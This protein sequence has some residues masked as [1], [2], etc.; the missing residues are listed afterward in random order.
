MLVY[1]YKSH[2]ETQIYKHNT[3]HNLNHCLIR[4]LFRSYGTKQIR[5]TTDSL[6][7]RTEFLKNKCGLSGKALITVS[8]CLT[9]DSSNTRPDSVLDL[10]R[11]FGF[12]QT[13]IARIVSI[14]PRCLEE[15][16]PENA[17]KPKLD[18]LLSKDLT[19][20]E[21]VAIV[22]QNPHILTSSL[23]NHIIP[24]L[25]LL[26]S[27]TGCYPNVAAVLK[28]NPYVLTDNQKS[29]LLNTNSLIAL[30]VP[31]SQILKLVKTCRGLFCKP[32]DKF[33]KAV[34]KLKDMGFDL[35][36][37]YFLNAIHTMCFVS[38]STWESRCLL[39][40]SFGFSN[41]E[42]L[43]MFKK[44]PQIMCYKEKTINTKMEFFLNK[45]Q[46][47]LSRFLNNPAVLVYSLEKRIIPRCSVLQVLVSKNS[48]SKSYM[49]STIFAMSERKFIENFVTAHKDEVPGVVEAYQGK[50]RYDEYT[51]K[52]KG[53]L[54]LKPA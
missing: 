5:P 41:D 31:P 21:V 2:L 4:P 17:F 8:K 11:S 18:F 45:L 24:S 43:S 51:F 46:W 40:R 32:H 50:L 37:S 23:H 36:S 48:T 13:S 6:E 3:L 38:D 42:I 39:F 33:R 52:P 12:T 34:F 30:G 28:C 16:I 1:M 14:R 35:K 53:Q 9:F 44:L 15:Y 22:T 26:L 47:T 49:L 7:F 29:F 25:E 20:A 10:F 27:I 19:Q 54:R